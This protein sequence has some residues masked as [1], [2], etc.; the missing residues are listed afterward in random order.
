VNRDHRRCV[1]DEEMRKGKWQNRK[2]GK[3]IES[4][5]REGC[6]SASMIG[7]SRLPSVVG[8]SDDI[9]GTGFFDFRTHRLQ[10]VCGRN[11]GE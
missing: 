1:V 10:V 3:K 11:N 6:S 9:V 2:L 8:C 7:G 4:C 5:R